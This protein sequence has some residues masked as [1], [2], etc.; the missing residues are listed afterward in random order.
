MFDVRR[1]GLLQLNN[2]YLK[3]K[4]SIEFLRKIVQALN[5]GQ[6]A[7]DLSGVVERIED[8]SMLTDNRITREL[9]RILLLTS[10]DSCKQAIIS[11]LL[12][13]HMHID[14]DLPILSLFPLW[15]LEHRTTLLTF[16]S[17][18]TGNQQDMTFLAVTDLLLHCA[19]EHLGYNSAHFLVRTLRVLGQNVILINSIETSLLFQFANIAS[20]CQPASTSV[21][22]SGRNKFGNE[23]PAHGKKR[24]EPTF[25]TMSAL[26]W[27][28]LELVIYR[29][30]ELSVPSLSGIGVSY[31]N[32]S[33]MPTYSS[34][35]LTLQPLEQNKGAKANIDNANDN[36][37]PIL[38]ITGTK[39]VMSW[40]DYISFWD[41][42]LS[43]SSSDSVEIL[44]NTLSSLVL[45]AHRLVSHPQFYPS[46]VSSKQ[47]ER[48][49]FF[50]L[51]LLLII[52]SVSDRIFSTSGPPK[53][54][55]HKQN[56][57]SKLIEKDSCVAMLT[58]LEKLLN[59]LVSIA[60]SF[61]DNVPEAFV[62]CY[63]SVLVTF[64]RTLA[65][66][67]K[68]DRSY[69]DTNSG[70]ID[71]VFVRCIER[72]VAIFNAFSRSLHTK[73]MDEIFK[74]ISA[75][76]ILLPDRILTINDLRLAIVELHVT[77]LKYNI[78]TYDFEK[79][80]DVFVDFAGLSDNSFI[81]KTKIELLG[82]HGPVYDSIDN[83]VFDSIFPLDHGAFGRLID[84][85]LQIWKQYPSVSSIFKQNLQYLTL[86]I[87]ASFNYGGVCMQVTSFKQAVTE[88]LDRFSITL[89]ET[90]SS[91]LYSIYDAIQAILQPGVHMAS[92]H[93]S[94]SINNSEENRSHGDNGSS[95]PD[96]PISSLASYS[97]DAIDSLINTKE[98]TLSVP[99]KKEIQQLAKELMLTEYGPEN[100]PAKDSIHVLRLY[101]ALQLKSKSDYPFLRTTLSRTS[102]YLI[103]KASVE[104]PELILLCYQWT[105]V[106]SYAAWYSECA[107]TIVNLGLGA[108]DDSASEDK[109]CKLIIPSQ[110]GDKTTG[111]SLGDF[112]IIKSAYALT[113][114]NSS[115]FTYPVDKLFI[116]LLQTAVMSPSIVSL[117]E[118]LVYRT[119]N[120]SLEIV[121]SEILRLLML[122]GLSI[123]TL[124][125][126]CTSHF[127]DNPLLVAFCLI[128]TVYSLQV[129]PRP[130]RIKVPRSQGV[131]L[132]TA[133][134][135][136]DQLEI[137]RSIVKE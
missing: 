103:L 117:S 122:A 72:F 45:L 88:L 107:A 132:A 112:R 118:L 91:Y 38:H 125:T 105:K 97:R 127:K 30:L 64:F 131:V 126:Y 57:Q 46:I 86:S 28:I 101:I 41:C 116:S 121:G 49:I 100:A 58:G 42:V 16:L 2:D 120:T 20:D 60:R 108:F 33:Y 54:Q 9:L 10:D 24:V 68:W 102:L 94:L 44:M 65:V 87:L 83:A 129:A 133:F 98:L 115:V 119:F 73:A 89:T 123:D 37:T 71:S 78:K 35:Y 67:M 104:F 76:I 47:T 135:R 36:C 22:S 137:L 134:L 19:L 70:E 84:L 13:H 95:P 61:P 92:P 59:G 43:N 96:V 128:A 99:T 17:A 130:I 110:S 32:S 93:W 21:G 77:V 69:T 40:A 109:L 39:T 63:N 4:E 55:L 3:V 80:K 48:S 6:V 34:S 52:A 62:D 8:A 81:F 12:R 5:S 29:A 14:L 113:L 114:E 53:H 23:A 66:H 15:G 50:S 82:K 136:R 79:L 74:D 31:A 90:D 111:L 25:I 85:L 75:L 1:S 51:E 56:G 11:Y 26:F 7:V 106:Y 18:V 27:Q 124:L